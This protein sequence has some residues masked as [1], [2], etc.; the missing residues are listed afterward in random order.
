M[1][2]VHVLTA[3]MACLVCLAALVGC[4]RKTATQTPTP[5][6]EQPA[7]RSADAAPASASTA[8]DP[9][10]SLTTIIHLSKPTEFNEQL[11]YIFGYAT[12]S[13]AFRTLD[14]GEGIDTNIG[15]VLKGVLDAGN[16][17]E[18]YFTT[19][20][21][22]ALLAKFQTMCIE[23]LQDKIEQMATENLNE[24]QQFLTANK[25][26]EGVTTTSSGLQYT[27]LR[28]GT[29]EKPKASDKVTIAYQV[30]MLNGAIVDSTYIRGRSE[31]LVLSRIAVNGF[32]EGLQLMPVGSKYR[33]WVAPDLAYGPTGNGLVEPNSLLIID[34][35]LEGIQPMAI[36][37]GR[38][39]S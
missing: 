10:E 3:V 35:E 6:S 13:T 33:F 25:L 11:S 18:S 4:S 28:E 21:T 22:N 36:S 30:T 34:V 19:E 27:V 12:M 23:A 16:G 2:R 7:L 15:Y 37:N 24:A 31:A 26:E 9:A 1:R 29:G 38:T 5:T 17:S 8:E 20:E 14:Q 39:A 32:V